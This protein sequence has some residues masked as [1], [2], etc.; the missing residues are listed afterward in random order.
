MGEK[1]PEIQRGGGDVGRLYDDREI[2][3]SEYRRVYGINPPNGVTNEQL[4]F[5]VLDNRGFPR[6]PIKTVSDNLSVI[7]KSMEER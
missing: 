7:R 4:L 5:A 3:E 2:L 1:T 6:D